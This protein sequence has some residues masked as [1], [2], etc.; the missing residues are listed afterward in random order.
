MAEHKHTRLPALPCAC[1]QPQPLCC[2]ART[3]AQ[4]LC[5]VQSGAPHAPH[6]P[7]P[8]TCPRLMVTRVSPVCRG[9]PSSSYSTWVNK[10]G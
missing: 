7:T 3:K 10:K 9:Q 2:S 8:L 1:L 6:S 4:G 5:G